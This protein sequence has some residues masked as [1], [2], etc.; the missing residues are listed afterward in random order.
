IDKLGKNPTDQSAIEIAM[1]SEDYAI[2]LYGDMLGRAESPEEKVFLT[3]LLEMEKGHLKLLRWELESL[4]GEGFWCD[5]MEF[6][7]EKELG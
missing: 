2:R 1:E 5:M 3:E 6:S 7:V 4:K